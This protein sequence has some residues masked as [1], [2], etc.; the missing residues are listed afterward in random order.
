[1]DRVRRTTATSSR[2]LDG[3]HPKLGL[4]EATVSAVHSFLPA[5]AE[6]GAGDAADQVR[7]VGHAEV[8]ERIGGGHD[9]VACADVFCAGDARL[10]QP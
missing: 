9:L 8:V 6:A 1:M 10:R 4:D 2:K 7:E 5:V 3:A